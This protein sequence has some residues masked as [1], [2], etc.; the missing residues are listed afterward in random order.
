MNGW[1]WA[2]LSLLGLA[3]LFAL[4]SAVGRLFVVDPYPQ[5]LAEQEQYE[6]LRNALGG[7][8]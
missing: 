8:R 1:G 3:A 6:A 7:A 4:G 5:D 2:A